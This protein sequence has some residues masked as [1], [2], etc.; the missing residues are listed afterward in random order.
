ARKDSFDVPLIITGKTPKVISR[1]ADNRNLLVSNWHSY[2]VSVLAVDTSKFPFANLVD[3]IPV[4]SIPRGIAIEEE[5]NRSFVAIM[6][7][8][9]L[10]VINNS[11]WMKEK[12]IAVESNPRHIVTDT[13]GHLFVSYNK[14]AKIACI[15]TESGKTLFTA[16]T[17]AQPRT[18]ILSKNKKFLFVTCYSS[19]MVEVFRIDE[20]KFTRVASLPC[21][22]HPVGVDIYEDDE[23]LEAWV[24][25]YVTGGISVF[26]FQKV[27]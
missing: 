5:R 9:S 15:D 25:S 4:S 27:N 26:G 3:N 18:L 17:K 2:N 10:T 8:S 16:R 12:D 14:L 22:G 11:V 20:K 1:T 13:S 23:T 21:P 24:C 19:D 7:G 6:G